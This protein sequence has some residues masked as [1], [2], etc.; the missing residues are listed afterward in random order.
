MV[1]VKMGKGLRE[2]DDKIIQMSIFKF[3]GIWGHQGMLRDPAFA[4]GSLLP[5]SGS[6]L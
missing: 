5:A 2:W 1:C 3:H 6:S 4:A